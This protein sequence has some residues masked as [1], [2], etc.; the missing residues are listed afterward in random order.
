MLPTRAVSV[1][2]SQSLSFCKKEWV[3]E[4]WV[5]ERMWRWI[6][7]WIWTFQAREKKRLKSSFHFPSCI[8]PFFLSSKQ[9]M[10][11]PQNTKICNTIQLVNAHGQAMNQTR[12]YSFL[13]AAALCCASSSSNED[14]PSRIFSL[15]NP[16]HEMQCWT[17]GN[18]WQYNTLIRST[19]APWPWIRSP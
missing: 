7:K 14:E 9:F 8:L 5:D 18:A 15:S 17:I 19:I 4:E 2:H 6:G 10:H 16:L 11:G 3:Q 1:L 13:S 12:R